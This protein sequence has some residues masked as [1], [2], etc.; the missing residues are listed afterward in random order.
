LQ[1]DYQARKEGRELLLKFVLSAMPTYYM[2]IF[3]V[4][5]WGFKH[6][7]RFRRSFLWKGKDSENVNGGSLSGE[8]ADLFEA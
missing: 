3:K 8:L 7:H 4:P 6:I 2:T 1:R 5:K